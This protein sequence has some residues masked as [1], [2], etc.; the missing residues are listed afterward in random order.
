M[1]AVQAAS[2][3]G[4][5]PHVNRLVGVRRELVKW[6]D[7]PDVRQLDEQLLDTLGG[8]NGKIRTPGLADMAEATSE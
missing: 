6:N 1:K 8:T 4:L 7:A 3:T 2:R 5:L